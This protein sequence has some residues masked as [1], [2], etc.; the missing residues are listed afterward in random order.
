ML[1]TVDEA[2]KFKESEDINEY[3]ELHNTEQFPIMYNYVIL[4][5]A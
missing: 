3:Y 1:V 4:F 5:L 2:F